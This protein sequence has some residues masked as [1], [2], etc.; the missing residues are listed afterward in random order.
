LKKIAKSKMNEL[1]ILKDYGTI[2]I[3]VLLLAYFSLYVYLADE[4][5]PVDED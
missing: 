5:G 2:F 4:Y 1:G 3:F